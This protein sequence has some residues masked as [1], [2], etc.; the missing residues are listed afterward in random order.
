MHRQSAELA[1]GQPH[2]EHQDRWRRRCPGNHLS[3]HGQH[4]LADGGDN[5]T[6]FRQGTNRFVGEIDLDAF[7]RY[8]EFLGTVN[9][10]P[11]NRITLVP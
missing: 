1:P 4:F 10:G 11:Q 9:P 5:Y 2:L 8:I 7:A 6:V 3:G